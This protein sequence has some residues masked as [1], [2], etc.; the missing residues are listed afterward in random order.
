[1]QS[2]HILSIQWCAVRARHKDL[3]I[4]RNVQIGRWSTPDVGKTA[5]DVV[6]MV[7]VYS[8]AI[9]TI[10]SL[11]TEVRVLVVPPRL[12]PFA[13]CWSNHHHSTGDL[14]RLLFLFVTYN[15]QIVCS[16]KR[17]YTLHQTSL[18]QMPF[19][20]TEVVSAC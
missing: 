12:S 17:T 4:R 16:E 10:L 2:N 6:R 20:I 3:P 11:P 1:M 15:Y 19:L 9:Y 7:F 8:Y 14:G 13:E 5:Q 18:T